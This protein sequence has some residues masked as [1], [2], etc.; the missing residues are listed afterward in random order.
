LA[1]PI[2]ILLHLLFDPTLATLMHKEVGRRRVFTVLP[3]VRVQNGKP[4]LH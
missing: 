2:K 3:F 1:T 4:Q